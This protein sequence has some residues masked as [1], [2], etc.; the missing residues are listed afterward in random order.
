MAALTYETS[1]ALMN[2]PAFRGRV[3]VA[4][5]KYAQF[6]MDEAPS[7]AAHSTRI[8]WAQQT[9][10]SPD[11]AAAVT[12][13]PTVMDTAVQAAGAAITDT[14]LQ[15]SVEVTVNKML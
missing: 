5:L 1:A 12:T 11:Q 9:M 13:P 3:K 8:K 10:Q 4:C 15:S 14:A 2:D 6:I 7:V